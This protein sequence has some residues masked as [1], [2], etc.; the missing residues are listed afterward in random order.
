[1]R[2]SH[3]WKS[4]LVFSLSEFTA[5]ALS[6]AGRASVKELTITLIGPHEVRDMIDSE[7]RMADIKQAATKMI[8]ASRGADALS[9]ALPGP[10]RT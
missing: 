3:V 7:N 1:M 9:L 4:S 2:A 5:E 6:L 8:L 10:V